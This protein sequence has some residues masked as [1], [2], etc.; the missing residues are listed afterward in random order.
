MLIN[1]VHILDIMDREELLSVLAPEVRDRIDR[2][3]EM[4]NAPFARMMGIEPE[5]KF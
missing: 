4:Y 5:H 2:V 3:E 1:D